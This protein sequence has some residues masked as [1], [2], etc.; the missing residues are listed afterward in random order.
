MRLSKY[1][2]QHSSYILDSSIFKNWQV[3]RSIDEDAD[4]PLVNYSLENSLLELSCDLEDER[5]RSL[6][7]KNEEHL[8]ETLSDVSFSIDRDSLAQKFGT[9]SKSGKEFSDP[10]LGEYGP[11][12]RFQM[13]EYTIHFQFSVDSKKIVMM[14]LMRNDVLP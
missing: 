3:Q 2:G 4:P 12:D 1:L 9:P 5:I 10:I 7:I 14:T 8:G 13:D 6:F 11:W